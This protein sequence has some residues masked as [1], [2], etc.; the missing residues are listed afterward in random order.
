M[1]NNTKMLKSKKVSGNILYAN[2]IQESGYLLCKSIRLP[3][4]KSW[5]EGNSTYQLKLRLIDEESKNGLDNNYRSMDMRSSFK[6][7]NF[8]TVSIQ[9]SLVPDGDFKYN[10][11]L[12]AGDEC[13]KA[14]S[15]S[16]GNMLGQGRPNRMDFY[17]MDNSSPLSVQMYDKD[18]YNILW[19]EL[20]MLDV[21]ER[22]NCNNL[23]NSSMSSYAMKSMPSSMRTAYKLSKY[24]GGKKIKKSKK[25]SKKSKKMKKSKKSKK[26]LKKKSKKCRYK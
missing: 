12:I 11:K 4:S 15:M 17:S 3:N 21:R 8:I 7:K 19:N 14:N 25:K 24:L 1:F 5:I 20:G 6:S 9:S 10:F 18:N 23:N 16:V 26:K 22:P 2:R 13:I